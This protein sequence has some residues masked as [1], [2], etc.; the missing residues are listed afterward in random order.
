MSSLA[1]LNTGNPVNA[2]LYGPYEQRS[3]NA[4]LQRNLVNNNGSSVVSRV[5][6]GPIQPV[7]D[8][9]LLTGRAAPDPSYV[10]RV[11]TRLNDNFVATRPRTHLMESGDTAEHK[12]LIQGTSC[13]R[14]RILNWW[15]GGGGQR[16]VAPINSYTRYHPYLG[17]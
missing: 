3:R 2:A 10:E 15:K 14:N 8:P 5:P 17:R 7:L 11:S 4:M 6:V 16:S 12:L 13:M 9:S 1:N